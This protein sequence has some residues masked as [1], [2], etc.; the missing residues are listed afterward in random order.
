MTKVC[1]RC[2]QTFE[3]D[4]HG[5]DRHGQRR[6]LRR[7]CSKRCASER[8]GL[9][10]K[11]APTAEQVILS[12]GWYEGEGSC[13]SASQ[14]VRATVSQTDRWILDQL[15]EWFGGRVTEFRG[16]KRLSHWSRTWYWVVCGNK[17]ESFLRAIYPWLSPRRRAQIDMALFARGKELVSF[18]TPT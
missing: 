7:F 4:K 17:A 14:T 8:P 1:V 9:D 16:R 2:G 11:R 12:A 6:H 15:R 10:R 5:P 3:T 13:S 18:A